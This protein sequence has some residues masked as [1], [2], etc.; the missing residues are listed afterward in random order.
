MSAA[1]LAVVPAFAQACELEVRGVAPDA[2]SNALEELRAEVQ[3]AP[4]GDCARIRVEFDQ[5]TA[6]L[7]FAT[8]DGRSAERELTDPRDLVATIIALHVVG[9]AEPL[10]GKI[11]EPALTSPQPPRTAPPLAD[12][13]SVRGEYAP[14]LALL[15]G[16]RGGASALVS[17][18]LLGSAAIELHRWE[19]SVLGG[20]D[21]HY[22]NARER[23]APKSDTGAV[24]LGIGVGRRE[25]VGP[26]T[27]LGSG[28]L[29]LA[30]LN[31]EP[32]ASED[33]RG[34][35]E[36]RLGAWSGLVTPSRAAVR[37][38]ADLGFEAVPHQFLRKHGPEDP[39]LTP[40]WAASLLL[41]AE[42][43]GP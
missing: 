2:W 18:V 17:P 15:A 34:R 19:L 24:V 7:T 3:R 33:S 8:R 37:F 12:G 43:G 38:R 6:R 28:R 25:P 23:S 4:E 40:W 41:G 11:D 39:P 27:L 30:A 31:D 1:W 26:N 16:L 22:E 35:A 9:P 21:I 20:V 5:G 42:I 10:R 36:V 14:N 13:G 29:M 32:D